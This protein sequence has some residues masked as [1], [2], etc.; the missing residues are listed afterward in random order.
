[1]K[2]FRSKTYG[3]HNKKIV[4]LLTGWKNTTGQY[5]PFSHILRSKG[6]CCI[7]YEYE[8]HVLS[9]DAKKTKKELLGIKK[10]IL[11][12]ISELKKEGITDFSVFGTSLGSQVALMVANNSK[13]VSK[14]ILNLSGADLAEVVWSWN[15]TEQG[16]KEKL[17]KNLYTL[18]KLKLSWRV[19]SPINNI[20][21]LKDKKILFYC[22]KNDEVIPYIQAKKL[23]EAIKKR[24]YD[25]RVVV[26]KRSGHFGT[27]L[28]NLLNYPRYIKFLNG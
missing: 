15:Y 20:N 23:A 18:L 17:L 22:A 28:T 3:K 2:S 13:D 5:L 6:Y 10:D 11:R 14:I 8:K 9:P 7:T 12:K 21:K 27:A 24:G 26:N 16:F 25:C 19:V 1:M 4:F